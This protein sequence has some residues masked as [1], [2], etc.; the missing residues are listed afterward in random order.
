MGS[1]AG[2][3]VAASGGCTVSGVPR[4]NDPAKAQKGPMD[5]K[6]EA[7]YDSIVDQVAALPGP[8]VVLATAISE[9]RPVV[10]AD[11]SVAP[12]GTAAWRAAVE[13]GL[14]ALAARLDRPDVT[15][16]L[17]GPAGHTLKPNCFAAGTGA[18]SLEGY[19]REWAAQGEVS[20]LFAAAAARHPGR[21]RFVGL[22]DIVCPTGGPCSS[23]RGGTLLRWDGVHYTRPG[24]RIIVAGLV[25]RLRSN[26][27][28]LP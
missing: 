13:V 17:L 26:G 27:V 28:A 14:E 10:L 18:C 9:Y 2:Y 3:V 22:D 7:R 20:D 23:W 19:A 5:A 24:S 25:E 6:C 15:L 16:V 11:G 21:V 4:S 12:F 1:G 8:I